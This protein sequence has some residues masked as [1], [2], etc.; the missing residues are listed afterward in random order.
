MATTASAKTAT[1]QLDPTRWRA[2]SI[3]LVGAFMVMFDTSMM[4]AILPTMQTALHM[5]PTQVTW[6]TA[7]F[8]LAGAVTLVPAG[9]LGDDFGRRRMFVIGMVLFLLASLSCALAP[10]GSWLVA[11]RFAMGIAGSIVIPQVIGLMQQLFTGKGRSKAFGVYAAIVAMS[12]AWGPL[13]AGQTVDGF[14]HQDGW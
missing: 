6:A 12:T 4:N 11:S 7:G 8:S 5:S 9:R 1:N 2:L 3:G 10:N 14:G 13:I